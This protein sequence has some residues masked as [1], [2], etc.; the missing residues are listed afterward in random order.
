MKCKATTVLTAIIS[1]G[2][3][4]YGKCYHNIKRE[5]FMRSKQKK[6]QIF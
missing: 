2:K 6:L 3:L 5:N 4:I 1:R